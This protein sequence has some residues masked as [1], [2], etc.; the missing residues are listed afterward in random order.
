MS[1]FGSRLTQMTLTVPVLHTIRG[2][3]RP[4]PVPPL[5]HGRVGIRRASEP[6]IESDDKRGSR[7]H[8]GF[9]SSRTSPTRALSRTSNGNGRDYRA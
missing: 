3:T 4:S 1:W 5:P 6:A 8:R 7:S 9:G 2:F